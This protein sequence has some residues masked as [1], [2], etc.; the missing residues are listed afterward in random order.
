MNRI[1]GYD[2]ERIKRRAYLAGVSSCAGAVIDG[3]A[4]PEQL[5]DWI[6]AL[7]EWVD[8][9]LALLEPTPPAYRLDLEIGWN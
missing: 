6:G 2:I 8:N 1:A 4:T 7:A 5:C 3:N 9:P